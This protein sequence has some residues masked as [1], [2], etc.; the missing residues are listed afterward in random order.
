MRIRYARLINV[1]M[2]K[3][4]GLGARKQDL[5][6]PLLTPTPSIFGVIKFFRLYRFVQV[7]GL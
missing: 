7:V 1:I 2:H 6:A 3:I 4:E 5:T